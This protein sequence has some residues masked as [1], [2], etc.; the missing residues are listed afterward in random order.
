MMHSPS[1]LVMTRP[2]GWLSPVCIPV[3]VYVVCMYVCIDTCIYLA[4]LT[5]LCRVFSLAR[6]LGVFFSL[7]LSLSLRDAGRKNLGAFARRG[8]GMKKE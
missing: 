4:R 3:Y 8:G 5:F 7:S 6:A 1:A 2:T